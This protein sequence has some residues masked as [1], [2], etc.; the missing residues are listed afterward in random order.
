MHKELFLRKR[1]KQVGKAI[2]ILDFD[3][4]LGTI[5][6]SD[7]S[8]DETFLVPA[9]KDRAKSMKSKFSFHFLSGSMSQSV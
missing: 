4:N 7:S 2:N 6:E 8:G 5:S 3:F 9:N 1:K